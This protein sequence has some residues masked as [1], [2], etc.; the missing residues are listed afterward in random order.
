[1]AEWP[2]PDTHV[3]PT[4]AGNDQLVFNRFELVVTQGVDQGLKHEFGQERVQ[5]GTARTNDLVL[6]DRTVSRYHLKI[7]TSG[8]TFT[9]TDLGSTNG[10]HLGACHIRSAFL[11]AETRIDLGTT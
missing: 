11:D 1:M 7:E 2:R 5:V 6:T 10:T 3:I 9:I 4:Q 8:G